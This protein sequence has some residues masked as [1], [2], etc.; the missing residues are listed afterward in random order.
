MDTSSCSCRCPIITKPRNVDLGY[1]LLYYHIILGFTRKGSSM[2]K[3]NPNNYGCVTK[4]KGNRTRPWMVKV[5][6]YDEGVMGNRSPLTMQKLRN[7]RTSSLLNTMTTHGA[8]TGTRL[9][10]LNCISVGQIS[11]CPNWANP[12]RVP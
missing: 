3:R 11:S 10:W 2:G 8:L 9:R 1:T 4:L 6:I 7:R 5:T 12:I